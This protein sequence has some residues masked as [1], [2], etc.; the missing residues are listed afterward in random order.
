MARSG[1]SRPDGHRR[2]A[3]GPRQRNQELT[4]RFFRY[5]LRTSPFRPG[6]PDLIDVQ[7]EMYELP[8]KVSLFLGPRTHT[9]CPSSTMRTS[10]AFTLPTLFTGQ[11]YVHQVCANF[12]PP[13]FRL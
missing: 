8:P 3:P 13:V 4:S 7:T 5:A 11:A 1:E 12:V 6:L 9:P 10:E 2:V